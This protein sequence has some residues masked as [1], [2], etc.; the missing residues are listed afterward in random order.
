ME[1]NKLVFGGLALGC[2]AAAG[3][4]GYLA[5]RQ[6]PAL[7]PEA[8]LSAEAPEVSAAV[9]PGASRPVAESEGVITPEAPAAPTVSAPVPVA[10]APIVTSPRRESSPKPSR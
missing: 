7:H 8:S 3:T 10:E 5:A 6:N 4:G 1:F 2:L 9:A